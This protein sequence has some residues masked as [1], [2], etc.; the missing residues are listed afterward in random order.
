VK[1][2]NKI[3]TTQQA[4]TGYRGKLQFYYPLLGIEK[5]RRK[6]WIPGQGTDEKWH[7]EPR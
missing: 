4:K 1:K 5:E 7:L 6:D 2:C 3:E